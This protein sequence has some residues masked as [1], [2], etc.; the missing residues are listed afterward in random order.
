MGSRCVRIIGEPPFSSFV[1]NRLNLT[2]GFLA[3]LRRL[4]AGSTRLVFGGHCHW[5]PCAKTAHVDAHWR[6]S[7]GRRASNRRVK[8]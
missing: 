1:L 5:L 6:W 8:R 3:R 2:L 4:I 7:F